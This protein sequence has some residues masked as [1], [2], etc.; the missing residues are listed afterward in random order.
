MNV[1]SF[2][3]APATCVSKYTP[4][5]VMS[6][7]GANKIFQINSQATKE[8]L[9]N[10]INESR[11]TVISNRNSLKSKFQSLILAAGDNSDLV[12]DK[13]NSCMNR[14]FKSCAAAH[15]QKLKKLLT[16]AGTSIPT[17]LN[18]S[19]TF[20][21]NNSTL[22]NTGLTS[23]SET[24]DTNSEDFAQ[25]TPLTTSS[26][27]TPIFNS[28]ILDNSP[29]FHG[30]STLISTEHSSLSPPFHGCSSLNLDSG[31]SLTALPVPSQV[32]ATLS[33]P[34]PR[35]MSSST[36]TAIL[37]PARNPSSQGPQRNNRRNLSRQQRRRRNRR[38]IFASLVTNLS[39]LN[40]TSD[41]INL[42][43]RGLNFWPNPKKL[44][45]TEMEAR[46]ARFS[47]TVRWK[48]WHHNRTLDPQEGPVPPKLLKETKTN[49]P[50]Q[51]SSF[52]SFQ[53][54]SSGSSPMP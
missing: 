53:L 6:E 43:S 46:Y 10:A 1:L 49:Y 37:S 14:T 39:S 40:L 9:K 33:F 24:Y 4:P 48:E 34:P 5:T 25:S 47:R 42:L 16:K 8:I 38:P 54:S 51:G 15:R 35:N 3:V 2:G 19:A 52:A 26:R 17:E 30:F 31:I 22:L 32:S 27:P 29:A 45:K 50:K 44:N 36:L 18:F 20:P 23:H 11:K 21:T 41:Q 12:R 13:V 28:Q 7:S